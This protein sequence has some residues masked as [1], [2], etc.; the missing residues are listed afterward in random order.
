MTEEF[1]GGGAEA[2]FEVIALNLMSRLVGLVI[3]VPI[4][5]IG[6]AALCLMVVGLGVF[7]AVWLLAPV[8]IVLGG[9]QASYL[10]V[11]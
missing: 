10:V 4:I 2:F 8:L 7:Y 1:S 9:V 5:C 11:L 6:A 3:R